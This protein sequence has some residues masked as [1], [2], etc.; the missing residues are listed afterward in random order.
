MANPSTFNPLDLKVVQFQN[1]EDFDFTPDLGCMYDSRPISGPSGAPGIKSGETMTLPY[2]VGNCLAT[3]LAKAA[4]I[5][6]PARKN[7]DGKEGDFPLWDERGLQAQK[8]LYMKEMYSEEKPI[9]MT[10][11]DRL[12]AKVEEYKK[13]VEQLLVTKGQPV[14]NADP[15]A[16]VPTAP[17]PTT[18]TDKQEVIAALEARGIKH[19]KRQTKANL[20][21]LL[22]P[23][24]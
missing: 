16:P 7:A 11:T 5:K 3:N 6:R 21:L 19:D 2:H 17:T 18:Y 10:E 24:V 23:T 1:T 8:V 14:P 20:E 13:M 22:K 9:A 12:M 4:L 15:V